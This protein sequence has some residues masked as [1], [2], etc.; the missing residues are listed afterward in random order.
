MTQDTA[1]DAEYHGAVTTDE[2]F[3]GSLV[4][5][6]DVAIEQLRAGR[7]HVVV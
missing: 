3:K 4:T 6:G 2:D 5:E 1:T 7:F